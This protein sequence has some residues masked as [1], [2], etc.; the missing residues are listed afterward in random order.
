V[1]ADVAPPEPTVPPAAGLSDPKDLELALIKALEIP[2]GFCK[3][4]D[5]QLTSE[6]R[7]LCSVADAASKRCPEFAISCAKE[8]EMAGNSAS[9]RGSSGRK[10]RRLGDR[11]GRGG[12]RGES[13][14]SGRA[15]WEVSS[16]PLGELL[17]GLMKVIFWALLVVGI[18]AMLFSA[19]KA[20]IARRRVPA[21]DDSAPSATAPELPKAPTGSPEDLLDRARRLAAAGELKAAMA[22]L[23]RALLRHLEIGGRIELHPSRTNGDYVRSLRQ[24]GHDPREL[25][26]VAQEVEAIEFGGGRA[27]TEGFSA[28]YERVSRLVQVTGVVLVCVSLAVTGCRKRSAPEEAVSSCGFDA[29]GYAVLCDTLEA[30]GLEIHRRFTAV[31]HVPDD[32]ELVVVLSDDLDNDERKVLLQWVERGGKLVLFDGASRYDK[33]LVPKAEC[34]N[35]ITLEESALGIPADVKLRFRLP[36]G[37]AF[38]DVPIK[39]VYAGCGEAPFALEVFH[40]DGSILAVADWRF[41]TNASLAIDQNAVL[42]AWLVGRPGDSVELIGAWTGTG[43]DLPAQSLSRSGLLPWF[44]QILLLGFVFALYRGSPFGSRREPVTKTRRAFAEHALALGD[45]YSRAKAS[46][47][48]LL[49][50]GSWALERLRVRL[51]ATKHGRLSDL[52]GAVAARHSVSEAEVMS[53]VVAV[54]SAEDQEHDSATE[55]EHLAALRRLSALVK[56]TGGS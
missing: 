29:A 14:D 49:N 18:G 34:K 9:G 41:A 10:E 47:I 33:Q 22:L 1:P 19:V 12:G 43:T 20:L 5:Y 26:R 13:R 44:L 36:L 37:R 52:A 3:T 27:S 25:K 46:R 7:L 32:V 54:R 8:L 6:E 50:F 38:G 30:R 56:K 21:A 40:G 23:L 2:G 42:A 16:G 17:G 4:P 39:R 55:A 15:S 53:L 28:L 48:A 11:R 31:E 24:R 51:S 45:A 35:D